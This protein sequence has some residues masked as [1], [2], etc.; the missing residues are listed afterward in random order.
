MVSALDDRLASGFFSGQSF[1]EACLSVPAREA[2]RATPS[3]ATP[4]GS[5]RRLPDD[6]APPLRAARMVLPRRR[7]SR[8]ALG[9]RLVTYALIDPLYRLLGEAAGGP[10]LL[11]I[12]DS[13]RLVMRL[14]RLST[15]RGGPAMSRSACRCVSLLSLAVLVG[16][17]C[18]GVASIR[19]GSEF[20][21]NTYTTDDQSSHAGGGATPTATSSSPGRATDQDGSS[22]RHLRPPLLERGRRRRRASSRST[23][24]P[25]A[26]RHV[27][28]VALDAD[29]DFVVAWTSYGQDGSTTASSPGASRAPASP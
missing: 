7:S 12:L 23:P 29:G 14:V 19:A 22:H 8:W 24:T 28:S 16:F 11:V 9:E 1:V 15:D 2:E 26:P 27:P 13:R 17:P 20:Q 18:R 3:S 21:V 25:P 4:N 5:V 10:D 6:L